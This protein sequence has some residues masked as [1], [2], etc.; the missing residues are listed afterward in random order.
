[1]KIVD[2]INK[3]VL[4]YNIIIVDLFIRSCP[5]KATVPLLLNYFNQCP[6]I[7]ILKSQDPLVTFNLDKTHH[8][9]E[10]FPFLTFQETPLWQP[11]PYVQHILN[12]AV[13]AAGKVLRFLQVKD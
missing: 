9:R 5:T 13:S 10:V 1:M 4:P 12:P 11:R 6:K 2:L 8:K 3:Q 7:C